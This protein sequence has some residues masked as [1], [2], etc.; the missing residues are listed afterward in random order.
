MLHPAPR[1]VTLPL[2]LLE[3][4][5]VRGTPAADVLDRGLAAAVLA[6][7]LG[8]RRVWLPE[9]HAR[10]VAVT[11]PLML[12]PLLGSR[13]RTVRL[14]TAVVLL[15]VRDPYLLVEDLVTAAH[16]CPGRLDV[17]LG[18]G[19][20]RGPGTEVLDRVRKDE[21]ALDQATRTVFDLLETGN[22]WI[23]ALPGGH[24]RWLHGA[25]VRSGALAAAAGAHYCHALFF[26][27]DL[28]ACLATL[29]AHRAAAPGATRAVAL[30]VVANRDRER[31]RAD[32]D[33]Q[34]LLVGCAGS[35]EDCAERVLA[36]LEHDDVD[37]VV[38]SEQSSRPDDHEQALRS[39]AALVAAALADAT[40]GSSPRA[41]AL[42]V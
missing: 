16:F 41:G 34:G 28:P 3:F 36:L 4:L 7:Q 38:L 42:V 20:V 23:D 30:A 17:G 1:P 35:P 18:R 40:P 10:G 27:P 32:A 37:E 2:G 11:N 12:L 9:H 25:G 29:A 39:I 15:R 13:T 14:G 33:L 26:N 19:D 5:D 31:A 24:Q 6:D 8:Y 22:D 21:D